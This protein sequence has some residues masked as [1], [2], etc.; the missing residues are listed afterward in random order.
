V[1]VL[2][3]VESPD[4]LAALGNPAYASLSGPDAPLAERRGRVLRYAGDVCPFVG[5]P[6]R[7]EPADWADLAALAGPGGSVGLAAAPFAPPEGWE[8]TLRLPGLQMLGDRVAGAP[9]EEAVPLGPADVPE[10]MDLVERTQPGPFRPGTVRLG[11]YLGIRRGGVLAAMA[12]ERL[13]P[14]GFAEVSA[15]CTDPG[16]RGQGLARRL[17]DAVVAGVRARGVRP[18]LHVAGGN[19]GAIRLYEAMGFTVNREVVFVAA[20]VPGTA[21]AAY[22]AGRAGA[23]WG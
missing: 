13:H 8:V 20:R 23:A 6:D 12:G 11:G 16:F 22:G 7:P 14:T 21:V 18:F 19:T 5:L 10:M 3:D 17:V 4:A 15:V 9:D 1:S 2:D